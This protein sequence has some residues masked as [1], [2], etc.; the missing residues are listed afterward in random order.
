[1]ITSKRLAQ[2]AKTTLVLP[3]LL[4]TLLG[5]GMHANAAIHTTSIS[6]SHQVT[7]DVIDPP[8]GH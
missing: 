2:V 4:A 5:L 7:A 1:M 3:F 6:S 8:P